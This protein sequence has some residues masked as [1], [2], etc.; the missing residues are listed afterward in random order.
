MLKLL[1]LKYT[2]QSLSFLK[3]TT[4]GKLKHEK[5]FNCFLKGQYLAIFDF[6]NG[7]ERSYKLQ[8]LQ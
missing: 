4:A 2:Q 5:V 8:K 1:M 3:S 7:K 6:H